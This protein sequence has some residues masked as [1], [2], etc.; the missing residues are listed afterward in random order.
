MAEVEAALQERVSDMPDD[1]AALAAH[2]VAKLRQLAAGDR[3]VIRL[4]DAL[5]SGAASK[6]EVICIAKL[7]PL[8]ELRGQHSRTWPRCRE[9]L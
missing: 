1:D 2:R 7:S 9:R 8:R 6:A 3:T 5:A 4:L